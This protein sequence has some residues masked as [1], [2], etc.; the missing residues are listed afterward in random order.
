MFFGGSFRKTIF[1]KLRF[2][3]PVDDRSPEPKNNDESKSEEATIDPPVESIPEIDL[4]IPSYPIES[5]LKDISNLK[6]KVSLV[7]H[8]ER[9]ILT[10]L[11]GG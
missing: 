11:L 2:R 5:N 6:S 7:A 8:S 10:N 1:R 9:D 3:E 4:D